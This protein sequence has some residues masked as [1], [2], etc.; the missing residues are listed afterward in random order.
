[1]HGQKE[2]L[3]TKL[4]EENART[5]K[6]IRQQS[7]KRQE[8][9]LFCVLGAFAALCSCLVCMAKDSIMKGMYVPVSVVLMV[10]SVIFLIAAVYAYPASVRYKAT[11]KNYKSKPTYDEILQKSMAEKKKIREVIR[12]LNI[13]LKRMDDSL[14]KKYVPDAQKI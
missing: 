14:E 11:W 10:I 4:D 2:I 7:S 8:V 6:I 13:Q 1:M 12:S 3:M 5:Q 9:M